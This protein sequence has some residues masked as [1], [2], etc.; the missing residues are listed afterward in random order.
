MRVSRI[1]AAVLVLCGAAALSLPMLRASTSQNQQDTAPGQIK[2]GVGL[3]NI[4][5]TVRDHHNGIVADLKQEDFHIF[6]DGV[7]QKVAFFSREKSLPLTIGILID[8][9][10]S[11]KFMLE[12]EKAA[13]QQFLHQVMQSKD[14]AMIMSFDTDADLLADWTTDKGELDRAIRRA[15]INSPSSGGP[16]T[17]GPIPGSDNI[18]TVFRDAVYLA[19]NDKLSSE[20]GRKALVIL[21]DAD[22]HGSKVSMADTIESAQRAD[23]VV[24]ILLISESRFSADPGAANKLTGE[25]GGRVI[26]VNNPSKMRAAFDEISDQL[27]SEYVLGYYPSNSKRDGTYRKLKID[28]SDKNEKVYARKGYYSASD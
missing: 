6:E 18:G 16:I 12:P 9:S 13:A 25:T 26:D 10:G 20:T 15:T 17:V 22:D 1:A 4:Y 24:H 7:E 23:T 2:V 3:V 28:V 19:C 5:A 8:T 27:R 14:E 11:E 21:T